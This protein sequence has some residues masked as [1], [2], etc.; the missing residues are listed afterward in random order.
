MEYNF[1]ADLLNK[2]SQLTPWIQAVL[3]VGLIAATIAPFYFLKEII[4]AVMERGK[5]SGD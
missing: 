4:R 2:Y 3:G 5:G 1:F